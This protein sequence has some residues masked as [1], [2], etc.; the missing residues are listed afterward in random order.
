MRWTV[1]AVV[2]GVALRA[3]LFHF[4]ASAYLSERPELSTPLSRHSRLLEGLALR[5]AGLSP[6][7]TGAVHHPPLLLEAFGALG[8]LAPAALVAADVAV[9]LMLRS[10]ARM[11]WR[12]HDAA[13][14]ARGVSEEERGRRVVGGDVFPDVVAAL[15]VLSPFAVAT[16]VAM[17]TDLCATFFTVAALNLALKGR[18]GYAMVALAGAVYI[19][20]YPV[21]LAV[22]LALIA[23]RHSPSCSRRSTALRAA[24]PLCA[25]LALAVLA[26]W[27]SEGRSWRWLWSTWGAIASVPERSPDL[28]LFWYFFLEVFLH[29]ERFFLFVFHAHLPACALALWLRLG[30]L[31]GGVRHL[32]PMLWAVCVC[33]AGMRAYPSVADVSLHVALLP[34]SW[35]EARPGRYAL[36]GALAACWIAAFAPV[37][38]SA[39]L[40]S[41]AGNANFYYAAGLA[42]TA[43]QGLLLSDALGNMTLRDRL[44]KHGLLQYEYIKKADAKAQ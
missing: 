24:A 11:T 14:R 32:V 3:A 35:G 26:S 30:G 6:Y 10:S 4:G 37:L 31:G 23:T 41:G 7:A 39:W 44:I 12:D 25:T 34:L 2:V 40:V 17:S 8:A 9:A 1:L 5:R 19:S 33:I 27:A 15:Y 38:W 22:P 29:F 20:V 28:G 16:C 21:L 18:L 13:E 43:A 42:A 36:A